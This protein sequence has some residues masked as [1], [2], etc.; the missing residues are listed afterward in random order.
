MNTFL[1]PVLAQIYNKDRQN[2]KNYDQLFLKDLIW[3]HAVKNS[4]I[5][6]SYLCNTFSQVLPFPTQRELNNWF[7]GMPTLGCPTDDSAK[8]EIKECPEYCRP[9]NHKDWNYC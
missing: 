3:S 1:D 7:V 8:T 9:K 2:L 6:D 5:H 4:L